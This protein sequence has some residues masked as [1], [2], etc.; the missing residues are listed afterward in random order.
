MIRKVPCRAQATM[1]TALG[2]GAHSGHVRELLAAR[3]CAD[4]ILECLSLDED[5]VVISKVT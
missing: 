4:V 5:Y 1:E 3:G 2:S